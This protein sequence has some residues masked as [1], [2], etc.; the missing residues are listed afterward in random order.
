MWQEAIYGL[1]MVLSSAFQKIFTQLYT[2]HYEINDNVLRYLRSVGHS[3]R[4]IFN[5]LYTKKSAWTITLLY[6]FQIK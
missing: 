1:V 3:A 6:I 2:L 5:L 4:G